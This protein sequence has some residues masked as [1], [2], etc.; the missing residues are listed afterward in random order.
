M[1][2]ATALARVLV[3]EFARCGVTEAV[4]APGSRSGPLASAL[5]AEPRIR[6]H[7]RI[8]ERS[9]SFLALG[10]AR[11]SGGPAILVCTSGTAAANLHPAVAEADAGHVPLLVLTADR[12]P[13]LRGTGASQTIDQLKLFGAAVRLF[14]EVGVPEPVAGQVAYWR[15]LAGRAFAAAADGPVHLNV[16]LREPLV[17]DSDESWVESLDGRSESDSPWVGFHR[18]RATQRTGLRLERLLRGLPERG[19]VVIGAD[20][21]DPDAAVDLAEACGWPVFAEPSSGGRH[22]PNAVAAYP[23]MLAE[24]MAAEPAELVVSVGTPGL[25]RSLIEWIRAADRHVVVDP[26]AAWADPTRTAAFLL[27]AVPRPGEGRTAGPWLHRWQARSAAA[28]VAVDDVLDGVESSC[29]LPE[30]SVARALGR[31]APPGALLVTG[32]S[33][34]VRDLELCLPPR[35]DLLVLANRG[36]NGIDG[37]VSTAIG[38]ALAHQCGSER[39]PAY[40]LMGDLTYLHDRN[41]LILGPEE[42]R[43]DLTLVVVDNG[44]GGIFSMLPQAGADGFERVFGTPHGVDLAADAAAVGVGYANPTDAAGLAAALRPRPG[45][46]LVH[47]RTDRAAT[48]ELHARLRKAVAAAVAG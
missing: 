15:S 23:L 25:S 28:A 35:D 12:P 3:D 11:V 34:S 41:G 30:P 40:A 18:S 19:A 20:A 36:A 32:P 39:N 47:V 29:G 37:V 46:R 21:T 9:A 7:V 4:L 17:P 6:L 13:E 1:N 22:G 31:T 2:P 45:L 44:G 27:D 24:P 33:R 14:T 10:L 43:P 16:A 8:D 42:P 48:A 38:A 5:L 26:R